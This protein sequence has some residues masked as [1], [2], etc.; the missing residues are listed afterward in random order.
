[1]KKRSAFTLI[2]L[3]MVMLILAL[4]AAAVVLK[5]QRPLRSAAARDAIAAITEYDATT[6]AGA[7]QQD[8]PLQLV[9]NLTE[10]MLYRADE[11]GRKLPLPAMQIGGQTRIGRIVVGAVDRREGKAVIMCSSKGF[12]PTYAL[13]IEDGGDGAG[14]WIVMAGLSGQA[15]QVSNEDEVRKIM[16]AAR[17]RNAG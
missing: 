17:G 9:A 6:R 13:L 14:Q 12:T 4:A 10:G 2:E 1:M 11:A 16:A 3:A 7:R 8:R 15:V 5:V